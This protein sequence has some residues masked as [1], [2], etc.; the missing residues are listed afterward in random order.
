MAASASARLVSIDDAG[1]TPAG[2]VGS[3][4]WQLE[5]G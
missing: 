2:L 5:D 4:T 3:G 1:W